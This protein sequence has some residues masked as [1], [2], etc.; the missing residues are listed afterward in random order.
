M[1]SIASR[2][3]I[4]AAA[5][6]VAAVVVVTGLRAQSSPEQIQFIFSSDAHY[7]LT[8]PVFQGGTNVDAHVVNAALVAKINSLSSVSF[9]RDGGLRSAKP[10]GPVD[11]VVQAGD[12]AN[13]EE[14]TETGA[15]QN[16]AASWSQFVS[17]YVNGLKVTT[18]TGS[19]ARLFVVPGNHDATNA[20]G[21]YKPMVPSIDRT[22]I[23]EIY[24]RMM[25][26]GTP[27]TSA[28]FN[29]A[30]DKVMYSHDIGG[31]HFVFLN[32]WPDSVQRAWMERDLGKVSASTPVIIFTHDQPDSESKHFTNP[33]GRHDINETDRF[34]NLLADELADGPTVDTPDRIEQAALEAFL[35]KHP[36]ITAYFHGNSNWN[37]FY[38]WTGPSHSVALHTF[39]VDSPMKGDLS[40]TDET[41]LSFQLY[42]VDTCAMLLTGREIL[43]NTQ[44][45]AA[46]QAAVPLVVGAARTV[47]LTPRPG[48]TTAALP[49]AVAVGATATFSVA[50]TNAPSLQWQSR[51]SGAS[52]WTTIAGATGPS[53]TTPTAVAGDSGTQFRCLA[54]NAS[55]QASSAATLTVQ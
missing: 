48:F 13:R 22:A 50:A 1:R 34:E 31:I 17:D 32:V 52:G 25:P 41:K 19:R 20:V 4:L 9:P 39:R 8:R 38:D 47:P 11:F 55:G 43:W 40:A 6:I 44:P 26:K 14:V 10:V 46:D 36:N 42:V 45:T 18:Q 53:Y 37:Q 7:G 49:Q 5:T 12:I 15:I 23:V 24:N 3:A 2:R 30:T 51:A 33:N 28:T 16:A 27:K 54:T 35:K 21:F 29:Y